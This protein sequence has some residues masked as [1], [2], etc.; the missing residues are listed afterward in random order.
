MSGSFSLTGSDTAVIAGITLTDVADGDWFTVTYPNQIAEVKTGKNGN[1]I[2]ASN[3]MGTQAEWTLRLL[4]GS[5]DDKAMDTLLQSQLLDFAAFEALTGTFVKRIGD[6]QGNVSPDQY[7][8][9]G[10]IFTFNV[11][12][13]SN[14]EGDTEQSVTVY[15]GK[16]ANLQ[17]VVS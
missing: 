11:D 14:A 12:A 17:R 15:R 5:P 16:F 2:F 6:G 8:G 4:R 10:G 9:S 13:K 3:A 7:V 1:S